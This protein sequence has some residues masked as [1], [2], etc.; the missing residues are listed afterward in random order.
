MG[1]FN[2]EIEQVGF[3][4]PG[5]RRTIGVADRGSSRQRG[6]AV[7]RMPFDEQFTA[8]RT[9]NQHQEK[10]EAENEKEEEEKKK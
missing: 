10:L 1:E 4:R 6:C 2:A 9:P 5:C 8:R 3:G 7:D